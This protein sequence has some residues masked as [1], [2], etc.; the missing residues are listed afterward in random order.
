MLH[1][2]L[3]LSQ[4]STA[5]LDAALLV[6][7]L[8][9]RGVL[10]VP[11]VARLAACA[12]RVSERA[13]GAGGV[14]PTSLAG[15]WSRQPRRQ[16]QAGP[17]ARPQLRAP[18]A[19]RAAAARA[20]CRA[21]G[22]PTHRSGWRTLRCR[23]PWKQ[24]PQ[25]RRCSGAPAAAKPLAAG[26]DRPITARRLSRRS[27]RS[28]AATQPAGNSAEGCRGPGIAR[29]RGEGKGQPS[30]ECSRASWR[31]DPPAPLTADWCCLLRWQM[32]HAPPPTPAPPTSAAATSCPPRRLPATPAYWALALPPFRSP[33]HYSYK[34][35]S[36]SS[37]SVAS[38]GH[39]HC[40]GR[41]AGLHRQ[42]RKGG[43][44]SDRQQNIVASLDRI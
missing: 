41:R 7:Q 5:H 32:I 43:E 18:P 21:A 33:E 28:Q 26:L 20:A 36:S 17:P 39:R 35:N 19:P 9:R 13:G 29:V 30:R 1:D 3:Q 12:G 34:C 25:R 10:I 6:E 4:L 15:P 16:S 42:Q 8:R 22:P 14:A 44:W 38:R 40:A 31:P 24:S 27:P 2:T 11:A 37:S 23:P